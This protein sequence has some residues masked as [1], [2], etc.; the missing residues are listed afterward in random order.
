MFIHAFAAYS[1]GCSAGWA[2]ISLLGLVFLARIGIS[3][4]LYLFRT[5][6]I[7]C[8]CVYVWFEIMLSAA[9]SF[10]NALN[11]VWPSVI[12]TPVMCDITFENAIFPRRFMGGISS[13]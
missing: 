3:F 11:P 5:A 7:I 4:T 8:S 12:L 6:L 13:M 2:R 10:V 9:T 1:K